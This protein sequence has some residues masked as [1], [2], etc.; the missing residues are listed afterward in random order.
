[1]LDEDLDCILEGA[2]FDVEEIMDLPSL[3]KDDGLEKRTGVVKA[4]TLSA[5]ST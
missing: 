3:I 4:P 5:F 2:E 1:M